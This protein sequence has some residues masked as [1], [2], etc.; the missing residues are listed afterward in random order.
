MKSLYA[1][2]LVLIV[3]L[4]YSMPG[5]A[6]EWNYHIVDDNYYAGYST[7]IVATSDGT[8]YILYKERTFLRLYLA[9]WVSAGDDDGYWD[10]LEI[11]QYTRYQDDIE[12]LCD[13]NDHLHM[14]WSSYSPGTNVNYAVFDSQTET[15]IIPEE[16]AASKEASLD[17]AI[18]DDEG[19]I[20]PSI[21][22][23]NR[24]NEL[25]VMTRDMGGGT[26]SVEYVYDY[27][28]V[29]YSP[30]IAADTSGYLHVSFFDDSGDNLMYATNAN[31]METWTYEYVDIV[32]SVGSRSSI[33]IDEGNIPYIVYYDVSNGDLKYAKLISE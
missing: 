31:A 8:P 3:L 9:H 16:I 15:W 28:T 19:T 7:Q 11:D 22:L 27:S 21:A 14:A 2:I 32:G 12:M 4:S 26:W 18:Y 30:S 29:M 10:R 24:D 6:Q 23:I 17:L 25:E 5:I 33:V 13:A 1:A 20:I